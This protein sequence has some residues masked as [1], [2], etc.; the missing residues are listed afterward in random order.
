L[1]SQYYGKKHKIVKG[2]KEYR[3]LT[4]INK[5][6]LINK[7]SK[8]IEFEA[9]SAGIAQLL[10]TQYDARF[11]ASALDLL[12]F[13]Y[14]PFKETAFDKR[15]FNT[16]FLTIPDYFFLNEVDTISSVENYKDDNHSHPNIEK[17]KNRLSA[18]I[19]NS[20]KKGGSSIFILPETQFLSMRETARFELVGIDLLN[21][22]YGNSIFNAFLLLKDYPE[23][24]YLKISIGKALYCLSKYKNSGEFQKVAHSY[25]KTEGESQQVH[26]LLRQHTKQQL[27]YCISLH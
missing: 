22:E 15:I 14:L 3:R 8:E 19:D 11:A 20:I 13:N 21:Q 7:Y 12:H 25:T 10:G 4:S 17:R 27:Y 5:I 24:K 2:K 26:F 1:K 16:Q 23:N 6:D 9:D 18:I